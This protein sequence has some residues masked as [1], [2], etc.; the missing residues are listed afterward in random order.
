MDNP[1]SPTEIDSKNKEDDSFTSKK[2]ST[3]TNQKKLPILSSFEVHKHFTYSTDHFL[4]RVKKSNEVIK[5]VPKIATK[6][7]KPTNAELR[8]P[9]I[10]PDLYEKNANPKLIV[11]THISRISNSTLLLMLDETVLA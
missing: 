2:S 4:P 8:A 6:Q 11:P 1:R 5:I 3:K 9:T 10:M 7:L